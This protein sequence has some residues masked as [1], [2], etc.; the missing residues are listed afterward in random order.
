MKMPRRRR[1]NVT[2]PLTSM[3]DIAFLL[4]IFFIL[5][6]NFIKESN[7]KY[8]S[9]K[10]SDVKGVKEGKVSVIIDSA[11][12]V[13]LQGIKAPSADI[14]DAVEAL[15]AGREGDDARLVVLRC[16]KGVDKSVFEP[17]IDAIARAGGTIVAVGE[18]TSGG[19]DAAPS[20]PPP[21]AA[22]PQEQ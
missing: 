3:G 20:V 1:N 7:I 12:D 16:D 21:A 6:S 17:V 15:L 13:Y 9:P 5:C 18:L 14:A 10:S 22:P 2:V 8:E 11:G 4:L 19:R